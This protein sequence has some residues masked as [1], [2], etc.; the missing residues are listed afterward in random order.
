MDTEVPPSNVGSG[1]VEN[2]AVPAARLEPK[3]AISVPG[4]MAGRKLASLTMPAEVV[5]GTT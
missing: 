3:M 5:P 2:W 4:A 1:V